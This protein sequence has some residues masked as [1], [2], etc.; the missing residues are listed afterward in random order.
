MPLSWEEDN[1]GS[2]KGSPSRTMNELCGGGG[3]STS[4]HSHGM[5]ACFVFIHSTWLEGLLRTYP[6]MPSILRAYYVLIPGSRVQHRDTTK[7]LVGP[8]PLKVKGNGFHNPAPFCVLLLH[9]S[10]MGALK[11]DLTNLST[12]VEC[13]PPPHILLPLPCLE[14][15]PHLEMAKALGL[16]Q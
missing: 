1:G 10:G 12:T 9:G 2:E 8:K 11:P 13:Q 16:S 4:W 7:G 14:A 5:P 3:E 15:A 6:R